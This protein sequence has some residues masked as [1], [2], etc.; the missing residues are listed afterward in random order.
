MNYYAYVRS[1]LF[2][3]FYHV[4]EYSKKKSV[5]D[6]DDILSILAPTML[7]LVNLQISRN[8]IAN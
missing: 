7:D 3:L 8:D 4:I 1:L 2:R 6:R 5:I